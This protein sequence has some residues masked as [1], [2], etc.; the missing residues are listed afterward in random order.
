[1]RHWKQV[2]TG[3]APDRA[4]ARRTR[5]LAFSGSSIEEAAMVH[6]PKTVYGYVI[7]SLLA[8]G[9]AWILVLIAQW[10][11]MAL[12]IVGVVALVCLALYLWRQ[13]V[14]AERER[15]WVGAFSFGDVVAARRAREAADTA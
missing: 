5:D 1:V 3:T 6:R 8:I 11:L 13:R 7:L 4:Y 2:V 10:S 15:A 12:A 14:E 9:I